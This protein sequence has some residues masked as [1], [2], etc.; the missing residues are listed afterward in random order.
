MTGIVA[1]VDGWGTALTIPVIVVAVVCSIVATELS[2]YGTKLGLWL[3]RVSA[4]LISDSKRDRW[5]A[6]WSADVATKSDGGKHEISALIWAL[7]APVAAARTSDVPARLNEALVPSNVLVLGIMGM[8]LANPRDRLGIT[9]VGKDAL[10]FGVTVGMG[11]VL[12]TA[13]VRRRTLDDLATQINDAGPRIRTVLS[14]Q[15]A[16]FFLTRMAIYGWSPL[17]TAA[18]IGEPL[19]GLVIAAGIG[20]S[21]PASVVAMLLLYMRIFRKRIQP[22]YPTNPTSG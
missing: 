17:A 6:E 21:F 11:S 12:V 16:R 14:P 20:L 8:V 7:G 13:V 4:N 5:I 15:T 18:L 22:E 9:H 10:L 2:S 19:R 1:A 3:V